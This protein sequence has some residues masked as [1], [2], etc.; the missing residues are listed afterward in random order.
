MSFAINVSWNAI[1]S[2][3]KLHFIVFY[4]IKF[5]SHL[6]SF[7]SLFFIATM[8]HSLSFMGWIN[9]HSSSLYHVFNLCVSQYGSYGS[10]G[11]QYRHFF[12]LHHTSGSI[13]PKLTLMH[14][15][16]R[17][18]FIF[19]WNFVCFFGC[20]MKYVKNGWLACK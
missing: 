8:F 20:V 13:S 18:H 10:Y 4:C 9:F 12:R 16:M 3:P 6:S 7:R 19:H 11:V 15:F 2:I 14:D 5:I 1:N 17:F